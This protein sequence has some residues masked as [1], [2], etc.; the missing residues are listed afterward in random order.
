[1]AREA[2][3]RQGDSARSDAPRPDAPRES[4]L[5]LL[6]DRTFRNFLLIARQYK[7]LYVGTI[8]AQFALTGLSLVFAE[9][10][11][12]LFNAAPHV[13]AD[14]LTRVLWVFALV[15]L[16]RLVITFVS[17]WLT[18]LLNESVAY[19]MRRRVLSHLQNLPLSFHENNH[20][21]G[22]YNVVYN[23]LES[24]KNFVV[25]DVQRLISLPI[26]FAA[27]GLYLLT[28]HPLLGVVA[29]CIG[30]LQMLSN[31]VLKKP[32]QDTL[33][34]QRK[35]GREV[36]HQIG[37]TLQGIREVKANQME[38]RVDSRMAG[39]QAKGIAYNVRLTQVRSIRS[40]VKDLP[41]EVGYVVGI[42]I[43]AT[44]MARG[45]IGPGGLIAF[46]TLLDKVAAP[47]T[48]V[49]GV[50]NNLQQTL[51]ASKHLFEVMEMPTED[52]QTGVPLPAPERTGPQITFEKVSFGYNVERPTLKDV[53]F[54]VPP[55]ASVALV[56]P[57]GAGKTTIVKLLYRFY[58]PDAGIIR[59]GDLPLYE[60]RLDSLRSRMALVSQDI[61]LFDGTVRENIAVG[62]AEAT[63]DDIERAARLAQADEFIRALPD[64]YDSTIGERG[65]KLSHGQKQRLSIAR[66][67]LRDASILILDEPTSALDVE[68][69][70]SFQA[71]LPQWAAHCTKIIIAHR[72]TTIRDADFVV[73]LE[74]GSVAEAGTPTEL[75][76]TGGRFARYWERQ[77][78]TFAHSPR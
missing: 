18:S 12:R 77:E 30:P 6:R 16:L 29:L 42:A 4:V 10:S 2:V 68:T 8:G 58:Q 53:S 78:P 57:S 1:M 38:A 63:S 51:A 60:Y 64:G 71:T 32:F 14:L 26:A 45:L 28:V 23:E 55:G 27:V 46:I 17:N 11:R 59:I 56:G 67:I 74:N 70:A 75:L 40:I 13:P 72:L 48:T 54:C 9:A 24:A 44:L 20:S 7:W 52:R 19:E 31:L 21:S 37:E 34:A 47:F 61:F 43:G 41:G 39:L 22:A 73:F 76:R 62:R 36:F 69:E 49:V 33:D 50:I 25:S 66:A 3:S 5:S 35:I 65:I 15:S